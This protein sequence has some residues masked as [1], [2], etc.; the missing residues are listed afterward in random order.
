MV[1]RQLPW[2]PRPGFGADLGTIDE[3]TTA[4]RLGQR[5]KQACRARPDLQGVRD[6]LL[7]VIAQPRMIDLAGENTQRFV[8]EDCRRQRNRSRRF[9]REEVTRF[10]HRRE[11]RLW[12][13]RRGAADECRVILVRQS[14][15]NHDYIG[16]RQESGA[17]FASGIEREEDAGPAER[18]LKCFGRPVYRLVAPCGR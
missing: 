16:V 13:W 8:S 9:D 6:G 4:R 15:S 12:R 2:K 14:H 11:S 17:S 18:L 3:L 1:S 5:L 7:E 10:A